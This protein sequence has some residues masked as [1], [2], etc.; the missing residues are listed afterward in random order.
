MPFTD[1][2]KRGETGV[3]CA[4]NPVCICKSLGS[5]QTLPITKASLPTP[6][7]QWGAQ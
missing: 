3:R 6:Y 5:H 7:R 1:L 4:C 2:S